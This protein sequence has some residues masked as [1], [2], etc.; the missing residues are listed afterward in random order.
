MAIQKSKCKITAEDRKIILSNFK[1]NV[2]STVFISV[3]MI[4]SFLYFTTKMP[5]NLIIIFA[6]FPIL[7]IALITI[8]PLLYRNKHIYTG[9]IS[10]K[11]EENTLQNGTLYYVCLDDTLFYF[12]REKNYMTRLKLDKK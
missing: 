8:L 2:L 12:D 5:L 9:T 10:K 6:L 3:F 1:I 11:F 4:T 7:A